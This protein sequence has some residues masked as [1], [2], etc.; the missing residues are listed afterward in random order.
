MAMAGQAAADGSKPTATALM[1]CSDDIKGKVRQVLKLP[2]D[3]QTTSSFVDQLYTCTYT[4]PMGPLVLS[5]QAL[6]RPAGRAGLLRRAAAHA[7]ADRKPRRARGEGVRHYDRGSGRAQGQRDAGGRR[8]RVA[9]VFG[10]E[11]QKRTDLA[12]EIASDVLGCW[13]GDE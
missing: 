12:Y 8:H 11:Q 4:L 2:A 5:V 3:P 1:V 10:A 13:T 7:R 6:R 9:A